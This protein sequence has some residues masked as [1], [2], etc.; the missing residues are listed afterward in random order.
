MKQSFKDMAVREINAITNFIETVQQFYPCTEEQAL[1]VLKVYKNCK[2]VKL[3][4]TNGRYTVVYHGFWEPE[5]I[6]NA[7]NA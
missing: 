7:I 5:T 4:R 1:K 6:Q 2:V 3:D